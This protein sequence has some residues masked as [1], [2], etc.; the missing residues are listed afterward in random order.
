MREHKLL[1]FRES[2]PSTN[3]IREYIVMSTGMDK[4]TDFASPGFEL[5][6]SIPLSGLSEW[7]IEL[8]TDRSMVPE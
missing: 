3:R 1:Y 4:D 5:K 2:V 8:P 7:D 6:A